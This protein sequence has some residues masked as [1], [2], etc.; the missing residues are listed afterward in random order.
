MAAGLAAFLFAGIVL[1][2]QLKPRGEVWVNPLENARF[3]RLTDFDGAELD[4]ALSPDG[5]LV[6]FLSDR[7]GPFD[8]FVGQVDVGNFVNMTKGRFPELFHEQTRSVGFSGD[9]CI[10]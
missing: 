10:Q 6:T 9:G 3:T 1:V 2:R 5:R 8:A 4:A 7:D